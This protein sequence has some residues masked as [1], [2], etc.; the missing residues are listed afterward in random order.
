MSEF[1]KGNLVK[2]TGRFKSDAGALQDPTAVFFAFKNPAG[3]TTTYTYGT[4]AQLVKDSTGV[5]HV[6]LDLDAA[7]KYTWKFYSTGTG[8]A[9]AESEIISLP[10]VL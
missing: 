8:K 2:V 4:H 3:T 10:T 9:S 7:G 6:I 1:Q 5:Y